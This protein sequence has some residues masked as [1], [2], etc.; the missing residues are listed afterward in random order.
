MCTFLRHFKS[1]DGSLGRSGQRT[2]AGRRL[3]F[4]ALSISKKCFQ[5]GF[6]VTENFPRTGGERS[7]K[8]R[9][10]ARASREKE[11]FLYGKDVV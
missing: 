10:H 2:L 7:R 4:K 11:N 1:V 8:A 3:L 6:P 9:G 5:G